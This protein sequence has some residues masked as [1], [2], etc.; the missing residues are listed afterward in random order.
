MKGYPLDMVAYGIDVLPL[1][2]HLKAYFLDI[3][4]PWYADN[5][6]A[7]STFSNSGWHSREGIPHNTHT[8]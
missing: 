7:L 2:K 8:F 5:A 1:I 6:S 4:H 3:T